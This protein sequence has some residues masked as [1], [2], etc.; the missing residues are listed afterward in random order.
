MA[1]WGGVAMASMERGGRR[2]RLWRCVRAGGLLET[3]SLG[4]RGAVCVGFQHWS[5]RNVTSHSKDCPTKRAVGERVGR[6]A[7]KHSLR[8]GWRNMCELP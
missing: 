8:V 5:P 2:R 1:A 4:V 3:I 7:R 6:Q